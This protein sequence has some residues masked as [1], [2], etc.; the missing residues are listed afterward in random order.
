MVVDCFTW[1]VVCSLKKTGFPVNS[2]HPI[3]SDCARTPKAG[4]DNDVGSGACSDSASQFRAMSSREPQVTRDPVFK[5]SDGHQA[6]LE[7]IGEPREKTGFPVN[8]PHPIA[9][10]CARTPKAGNDMHSGRVFLW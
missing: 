5:A 1:R 8:S 2:P 7:R 3:A 10:D 9:G 4:N 6:M